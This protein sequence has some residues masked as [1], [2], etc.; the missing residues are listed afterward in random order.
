MK[1]LT[2]EDI[3]QKEGIF[4]YNEN[5]LPRKYVFVSPSLPLNSDPDPDSDPDSDPD[6]DPDPQL[7]PLDNVSY[8]FI[9][10]KW[11]FF[12]ICSTSLIT[13]SYFL[14]FMIDGEF[15][16]YKVSYDHNGIVLRMVTEWPQCK[17][18]RHELWR[19]LSCIF[20]HANLNHYSSNIFAMILYSF[21]L[22]LYQDWYYITPLF[23]LGTIHGNLSFYYA[24]PYYG[25]I[26]VSQGV[27]TLVGL[28]CANGILNANALPLLQ[29]VIIAYLCLTTLIGE[30]VS[31]DEDNNIAY[32][33]HWGSLISGILGGLGFLK[34]YQSNTYLLNTSRFF[35]TLYLAYGFYLIY[36]YTFEWPPLQSY[37]NTLQPIETNDCCFEWL[38][39]QHQ[40]QNASRDVFICTIKHSSSTS[41][42]K[43]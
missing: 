36:H 23:I 33:C 18:Q 20:S 32:I 31:Y 14:G 4:F 37:T 34:T 11:K 35:A 17:D 3:Y 28:N 40:Y 27:F 8:E 10:H 26:G 41:Y 2:Y 15:D 6:P 1:H 19:L 24:K 43:A 29:T 25:A 7:H 38:S 21:M 42:Y 13:F 30:A 16:R 9:F 12:T 5:P 39:Y 22:E